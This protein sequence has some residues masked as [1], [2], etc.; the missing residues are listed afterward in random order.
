MFNFQFCFPFLKLSGFGTWQ[1]D[2]S[3]QKRRNLQRPTSSPQ[4]LFLFLLFTNFQKV[5]VLIEK[6]LNCKY[7]NT[8]TQVQI[9]K[10][11]CRPP[12]CVPTS[13]AKSNSLRLRNLHMPGDLKY[14]KNLKKKQS[15][16][17]AEV[18]REQAPGWS[19]GADGEN[20]FAHTR[21]WVG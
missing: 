11:T 9:H 10:Y 17:S 1:H 8:N 4:R 19:D 13:C 20:K 14:D 3:A 15:T 7:K 2:V 5:F 18:P 21:G 16:P 12:N 6:R